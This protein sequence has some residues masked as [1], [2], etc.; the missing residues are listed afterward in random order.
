[1]QKSLA[2]LKSVQ[3]INQIRSNFKR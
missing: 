1:M 2:A 3:Y